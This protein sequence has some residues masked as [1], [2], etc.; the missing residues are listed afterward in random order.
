MKLQRVTMNAKW[1]PEIDGLRFIAIIA[2]L[3]VHILHDMPV[4]PGQLKGHEAFLRSIDH[5]NRGVDLFFVISGFI[6]AQPFLRQF[7]DGGKRVSLRGFYLRRLTRL[8]PPYLLSLALYAVAQIAFGRTQHGDVFVSLLTSV[9]Y[10]HNIFNARPA[11]N[12]VTW[13]LE[14]EI[15]FYLLAPLLARV[16]LIRSAPLR[17]SVLF[18]AIL[19]TSLPVFRIPNRVGFYFPSLLCFFLVGYLLADLRMPQGSSRYGLACTLVAL[20]SWPAMFLTSMPDHESLMLCLMLFVCFMSSMLSPVIRALLQIRFIAILGGM[21]Y[22]MYLMHIFILRSTVH[23]TSRALVFHGLYANYAAA[24]MIELPLILIGSTAYY[25]LIERPCMDP[26][27]PR[28][29]VSRCWEFSRATKSS[30]GVPAGQ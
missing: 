22:S 2:V 13:S 28:K 23:L 20:V 24:I 26:R 29:F 14:V 11:I 30:T 1:I 17:R 9:F 15:V 25:L 27:W 6:L 7:V 16:F 18:V 8:E 5:L 3:L 4:T 10:V 21:C 19:V 12:F